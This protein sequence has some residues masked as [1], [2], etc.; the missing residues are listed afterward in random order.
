MVSTC[1]IDL[2]WYQAN[3]FFLKRRNTSIV[4]FE[5]LNSLGGPRG[6]SRK[7]S[8]H[9]SART[10][11]PHTLHDFQAPR[12]RRHE[13]MQRREPSSISSPQ[14]RTLIQDTRL[15][16]PRSSNE[17]RV[18][19]DLSDDETNSIRPTSP[20]A[21]LPC[22]SS[23]TPLNPARKERIVDYNIEDLHFGRWRSS[24]DESNLTF[25][26]TIP[27]RRPEGYIYILNNHEPLEEFKF[28][29]DQ[30][31][32]I[33]YC[34]NTRQ[35]YIKLNSRVTL[36][37][38]G[39]SSDHLFFKLRIP[40]HE[41]E[42]NYMINAAGGLSE[43]LQLHSLEE[44]E[45][46][47][48]IGIR[49][50]V[51]PPKPSQTTDDELLACPSHV[52]KDELQS[53]TEKQSAVTISRD[54]SNLDS[55]S[56]PKV[57]QTY[58]TKE[59]PR[60]LIIEDL[61]KGLP[62]NWSL[63]R[64]TRSK[65]K[66]TGSHNSAATILDELNDFD[67]SEDVHVTRSTRPKLRLN[68]P[69]R[70]QFG[71][72]SVEI[73][74]D[75]FSRLDDGCYLNDTIIDFYLNFILQKL[76][77]E[78]PEIAKYT[79]IF[80]TFFYEKLM[81]KTKGGS[82]GGYENVRKWTSKVDLFSMKY[83]IIPINERAHWYLA[84]LSNLNGLIKKTAETSEEGISQNSD[85]VTSLREI[86]S[87][88]LAKGTRRNK[89][90]PESPIDPTIFVLDSLGLRHNLVFRP[91][92]EYLVAEAHDKRGVEIDRD[93][94]KSKY[95]YAPTQPNS[96]DC[97]VYLLHYV[98]AFLNRPSAFLP[99]LVDIDNPKKEVQKK[100]NQLFDVE[101]FGTKR[102]YI[103]RLILDL[104]EKQEQEQKHGSPERSAIAKT[105]TEEDIEDIEDVVEQRGTEGDGN[106]DRERRSI[107]EKAHSIM[108]SRIKRILDKQE[109]EVENDSGKLE[110]LEPA[111]GTDVGGSDNV[112]DWHSSG[113][114]D[115]SQMATETGSTTNMIPVSSNF[116]R[117][118][119]R[120]ESA[121]TAYQN[122]TK[123]ITKDIMVSC[124]DPL[125]T[126]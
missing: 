78:H 28:R 7:A 39:T 21:K 50:L 49:T 105:R 96:C 32:K 77:R 108:E 116:D 104:Q 82:T 33:E 14:K 113:L 124:L 18:S 70:Y 36:Y 16:Q 94:I 48:R 2:I 121:R 79:Y 106:H 68:K 99:S 38:C 74:Q 56:R 109:P 103:Q 58:S 9:I 93:D 92:R 91:L 20:A 24:S 62:S 75:D 107:F 102:E 61:D 110:E 112:K 60:K 69:L 35:F 30:L 15:P 10:V 80:N 120:S 25:R 89:N 97:G 44:A 26:L 118:E 98:E 125:K 34:L 115:S 66:T 114:D 42:T 71:H 84:I 51:T 86:V 4:A 6:S 85:V 101:K 87:K 90:V 63:S 37:Y 111:E 22:S 88:V 126:D 117:E 123:N 65:S 11:G 46:N 5:P 17:N 3:I 45:M 57:K 54:E 83:V 76:Q 72:K 53:P 31:R 43:S 67:L 23:S 1:F 100:L 13:E 64:L 47:K 55:P 122:S 12:K 41:S 19:I 73:G 52:Q 40:D 8:N 119:K 81:Q 59:E 95:A 29:V 27:A